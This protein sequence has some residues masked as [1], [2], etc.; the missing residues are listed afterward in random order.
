M[1]KEFLK[2]EDV[3]KLLFTL[4][5][6]PYREGLLETP[7]RFLRAWQEK[8][9]GYTVDPKKF[10]TVFEDGAE[11]YDQM[12]VVK[13]IEIE[14]NCEHHLERI[15]GVAHIGYLPNQRIIGL[16]KLYRIANALS[17]RL[18]VQER[19]TNQIAHV[20][21]EG[22]RPRGVGVVLE[23]RHSCM[24]TRGICKRGQLTIT[25][26]LHGAFRDEPATREEFLSLASTSKQ[27]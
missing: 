17:R 8:T 18:Q 7:V 13:D 23:C 16:S 4:G 1:P 19:L 15:W 2:Y 3:K 26:S 10:L 22:L 9:S 5:E 21:M 6:N 14:S 27:L 25:S 11:N 24:E 20:I 12:I